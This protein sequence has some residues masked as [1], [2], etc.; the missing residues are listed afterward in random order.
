MDKNMTP[1]P[2]ELSN[3]FTDAFATKGEKLLVFVTCC[4]ECG[5]TYLRDHA[6]DYTYWLFST[7]DDCHY[8]AQCGRLFM[9]FG[10]V[11]DDQLVASVHDGQFIVETLSSAG[12]EIK[13]PGTVDKRICVEVDPPSFAEQAIRIESRDT[14]VPTFARQEE[15]PSRGYVI[16]TWKD[17]DGKWWYDVSEDGYSH[18]RV[19]MDTHAEAL[20][21]AREL[22]KDLHLDTN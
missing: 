13:W 2:R 22:V 20:A 8:A 17:H 19:P 15:S 16:H 6:I 18:E 21:A 1:T 5:I 3:L 11:L 10:A 14:K 4:N 7:A 12:F 9:H